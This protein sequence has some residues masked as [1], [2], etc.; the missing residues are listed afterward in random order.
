MSADLRGQLLEIHRAHKSLTPAIVVDEATAPK[1]PLHSR[2]EW[3]DEI[4]GPKYRLV[5]AAELI[6]TVRVTFLASPEGE[7]E[8]VRAFV[9]VPS[10]DGNRYEPVENVAQDTF[11]RELVLR[12]ADRE[13]RSLKK[14]YGHLA[15]FMESVRRDV[16]S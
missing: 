8:F 10:P 13:W 5:Q 9:N 7:P 2:F 1:S 4:A 12:M 6:R 3:D 14:K 11:S 16:A 15:D